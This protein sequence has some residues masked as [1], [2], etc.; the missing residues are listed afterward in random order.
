[1]NIFSTLGFTTSFTKESEIVENG[2]T[3]YHVRMRTIEMFAQL[4]GDIMANAQ[5]HEF[6]TRNVRDTF[7]FLAH[8]SNHK[9]TNG[10]M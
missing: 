9:N 2:H 4:N 1:M 8:S 10:K 7:F 6:E 5:F 3:D